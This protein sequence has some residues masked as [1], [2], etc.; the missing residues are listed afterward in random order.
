MESSRHLQST[1]VT[2]GPAPPTP[3]FLFRGHDAPIHSLEFF[4]NNAFLVTGDEIGWIYVWDIWKRRQIYKWH[5][6]PSASVLALKA[7][8]IQTIAQGY[9]TPK[10]IGAKKNQST[11]QHLNDLVYIVSHG[12]DNEIHF[13]DINDILYKSLSSSGSS[14]AA[15]T[16]NI[17]SSGS[18]N[19]AP[20]F[21]LP[22]NAVNFCKMSILA[23]DAPPPSSSAEKDS[24]ATATPS[25]SHSE[26][27]LKT[28]HQHIYIAVPSPTTPTLID[29][30]DV[31]K[32]ERTFAS[33][34]VAETS[35]SQGTDKKWGSVMAIQL[36]QTRSQSLDLAALE[37]NDDTSV[38]GS[39]ELSKTLHMLVGYEDGSVCLF[40]ESTLLLPVTQGK[41]QKRDMEV[42]WSI[43]RHRE[44]ILALDVSSDLQFAV[45]CGS[46]NILV[47]YNL[48]SHLQGVPEVLQVALKSNGIADIKIRSD[49]KIMGLAGWD[50]RIRIF[51]AKSLKPLAVLKHHR[52]GLNCLGFAYLYGLDPSTDV[53][54]TAE[55][56]GKVEMS[57]ENSSA[58]TPNKH[59]EDD[60]TDEASEN[61]SDED[62][63]LEDMLEGRR[64]WSRR[65]WIA[66]GGKENRINIISTFNRTT[67]PVSIFDLPHILERVCLDLP[68]K[69]IVSCST[70]NF[71]WNR[72]IQPLTWRDFKIKDVDYA[73]LL[74]QESSLETFKKNAP[75]IQTLTA[76]YSTNLP[77]ILEY[78][79][80]NPETISNRLTRL[81][82]VCD[83]SMGSSDTWD[84]LIKLLLITEKH[85]EHLDVNIYR[86]PLWNRHN[87]DQPK[88]MFRGLRSL[89]TMVFK[90]QEPMFGSTLGAFLKYCPESLESLDFDFPMVERHEPILQ[91]DFGVN[92]DD[93]VLLTDDEIVTLFWQDATPTNIQTLRLPNSLRFCEKL[94]II[95]FLKYRCP[96]LTTWEPVSIVRPIAVGQVAESL[97]T[98]CLQVENLVFNDLLMEF[99]PVYPRIIKACHGLKSLTIAGKIHDARDVVHAVVQT[100]AKTM[101]AIRWTGGGGFNGGMDME[102]FL[103]LCSNLER[104]ETTYSKSIDNFSTGQGAIGA[105]WIKDEPPLPVAAKPRSQSGTKY[106]YWA[107]HATLTHLDVTFYPDRNVLD[108]ER[109]K[110]Q[111]EL[112]YR[113]LGQLEAL[114]ELRLGC[115]C[116]CHGSKLM[117][118]Q[119]FRHDAENG[120]DEMLNGGQGGVGVRVVEEKDKVEDRI[121]DMS[122]GTGLFHLAGLKKMRYLGIGR[123]Q[124]HKIGYEELLWMR[125]NWEGLRELRGVRNQKIIEW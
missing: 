67:M 27:P 20:I 91:W 89:K 58:S 39:N 57:S 105:M 63:D 4:A 15:S 10:R 124:G 73:Q 118:C 93:N 52:E 114:R 45:S 84:A 11:A 41:K 80:Q 75:T 92:L 64:Q 13:W 77:P 96:K 38:T 90:G 123:I 50:G 59:E 55:E 121:L 14:S 101:R 122:L 112:T 6:H 43:K 106:F 87:T 12:R 21:S 104:L 125:R 18:Q 17:P 44:P 108:D 30:Y 68:T 74:G 103:R 62:S 16:H 49:N 111:I 33:I 2:S 5:G 70:V 34:G 1:G 100:H 31:V 66:V 47:K 3:S 82:M 71:Q 61:E 19:L 81:V 25:S 94:T 26:S 109:F 7:I 37:L 117:R 36:F 24:S 72:V 107:C 119:H 110:K 115:S 56:K 116:R 32:P 78:L 102:D 8:P 83:G 88:I 79:Q 29:I 48:S 120:A 65:H 42:L 54:E 46:D 98:G 95:P 60:E 85:L 76:Q 23:I 22:V 51:S 86:V 53:E 113:K 97:R 35:I 99:L 9:N 69:D 28:T 40:R